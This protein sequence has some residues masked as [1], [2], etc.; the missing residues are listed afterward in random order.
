MTLLLICT[1][2]EGVKFNF[3]RKLA[4]PCIHYYVIIHT[5]LS[6]LLIEYI[7]SLSNVGEN[8]TS[9]IQLQATIWQRL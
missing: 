4:S 9:Y 1:L 2:I 5:V 8:I 6:Y 3:K 7:E